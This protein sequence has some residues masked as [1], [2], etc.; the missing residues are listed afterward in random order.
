[1]SLS[2]K[3]REIRINYL[4][5]A[6][7]IAAIAPLVW[8]LWAWFTDNLS[9]NP[10]QAATLRTG[11]FALIYLVLTLAITPAH[12]L[13]G[14]HPLISVRRMLGL[15]TF[16]YAA[17]HFIIFSW[18]DYGLNA[19][20]IISEII[21]KR[22]TIVGAAALVILLALAVTSFRWWMKKLGKNWKRLHRLVYLAGLLVV[23]HYAWSKKG[24]I[25][26]LA[27]D[28]WQPLLF[29]A[30]ILALLVMRLPR[31]RRWISSTSQ[32]LRAAWRARTAGKQTLT[33]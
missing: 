7:H 23:L 11:K 31:V 16:L 29:G 17:I 30:I 13:T 21:N 32:R 24:D 10:I 14:Y 26:R 5:T 8:L 15:Y 28:I 6:V 20:L 2:M 25:F 18:L 19:Q 9:I 22:Y 33:S 1:M 3:P 12:I 4:K 27:G